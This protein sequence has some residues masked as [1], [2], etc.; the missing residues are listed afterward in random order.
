MLKA[1]REV[2]PKIRFIDA[3]LAI[4]DHVGLGTL[5]AAYSGQDASA[6]GWFS[7]KATEGAVRAVLDL[8]ITP[9][10]VDGSAGQRLAAVQTELKASRSKEE[11]AALE[12][13][14]FRDVLGVKL[15]T[16]QFLSGLSEADRTYADSVVANWN[17]LIDERLNLSRYWQQDDQFILRAN[18]KKGTI[19]FEITGKT[20]AVYSFR[21]RSSG[22][23]YFLS[24]Y[25]QAKA[26]ERGGNKHGIVLMD[27]PDS[28]LSVVGQRNLLSV[29]E[30]LVSPDSSRRKTQLIYTTHSPFLINRNFPRRL[31]LVR[32][33]DGEEGTV[34]VD[35]E[36][37]RRYEPVR[38]A[39]GIDC[40]QTM[41]MGA[42][43]LDPMERPTSA[44]HLTRVT[45]SLR[46]LG[47][48]PHTKEVGRDAV[49]N[50]H[51]FRSARGDDG[52]R[53]LGVGRARAGAPRAD[54]R[55]RRHSEICGA[56]SAPA[57]ARA[58]L[59]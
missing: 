48:E 9:Q 15:E 31:R 58:V 50:H 55:E 54:V 6:E 59:L 39:L 21:E 14:L 38:S 16:L 29:F 24:Y 36:R 42:T 28:F 43:N 23:R 20:G 47:A 10:G 30:S 33:G 12:A 11:P 49:Y 18:L 25:I 52:G 7:V 34:L 3:K 22:L 5:I 56:R 13:L 19:F 41:F 4:N 27:E 32:K 26:I 51:C 8:N 1:L 57:P 44:L 46:E 37:V 2:F 53:G 35:E 17:Q 45:L 40:A